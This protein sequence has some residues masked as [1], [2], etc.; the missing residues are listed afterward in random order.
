MCG[1]DKDADVIHRRGTIVITRLA[2]R[3]GYAAK[4]TLS[5]PQGEG[6]APS[7]A[8]CDIIRAVPGVTGAQ[9]ARIESCWVVVYDL[10]PEKDE[11]E[12]AQAVA[13]VVA[14]LYGE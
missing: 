9:G 5:R 1:Q 2:P 7:D 6:G 3:Q 4:Q 10:A 8:L 11:L 12:V 14:P 13:A